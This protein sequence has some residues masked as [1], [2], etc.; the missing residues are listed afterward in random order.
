MSPQHELKNGKPLTT[1][2]MGKRL[3]NGGKRSADSVSKFISSSISNIICNEH[4]LRITLCPFVLLCPQTVCQCSVKAAICILLRLPHLNL[5]SQSYFTQNSS[6]NHPLPAHIQTHL[7]C[8]ASATHPLIPSHYISGHV[9][10]IPFEAL[11]FSSGFRETTQ[12]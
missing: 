11:D 10:I 5:H 7:I 2:T 12:A 3:P 9:Y 4:I 1:E 6:L 8:Q